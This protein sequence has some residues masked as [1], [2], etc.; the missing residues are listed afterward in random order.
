M[1]TSWLLWLSEMS[2]LSEKVEESKFSMSSGSVN[3]C[4]VA[5]ELF[6][7]GE[8]RLM[9]ISDFDDGPHVS[10]AHVS[11]PKTV[12]SDFLSKIWNISEDITSKVLIKLLSS[13]NRELIMIYHV[14]FQPMIGCSDTAGSIVS[15][16]LIPSSLLLEVNRPVGI[17]V[18]KYM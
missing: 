7:L 17:L 2:T 11:K 14:T 12:S 6:A 5:C 18:C 13:T 8:P 16:S 10:A 4:N 1:S 15:S 9:D 3:M